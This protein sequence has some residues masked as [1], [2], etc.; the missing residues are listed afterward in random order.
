M[1]ATSRFERAHRLV[2]ELVSLIAPQLGLVALARAEIAKAR[3]RQQLAGYK[4][5]DICWNML[6]DLYV[7]EAEGR[8]ISVSSACIAAMA[9]Q[10]TALRKIV[11]LERQGLIERTPDKWD[12]RRII[13]ALSAQGRRVV[14]DYLENSY[15]PGATSS[16]GS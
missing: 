10:T 8:E 2:D 4:A 11:N 14:G 3:L 13:M 9:P 6:L 15:G 16:T 12:G 1:T 7:S 5:D